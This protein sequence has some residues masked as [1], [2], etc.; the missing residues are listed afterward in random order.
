MDILLFIIASVIKFVFTPFVWVYSAIFALKHG[1]F[2]KWY[3]ELAIAKDAYGNVLMQYGLNQAFRKSE[4]YKFGNRKETI[5]S[6]IG[7]NKI[8][9][10]LTPPGKL[11]DWILE[12][13]EKNHSIKSIDNNI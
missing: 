5:S 3:R 12:K 7:K 13:A 2:N 4:G 9:N 6:V 1:E 10:T 8:M 11:V